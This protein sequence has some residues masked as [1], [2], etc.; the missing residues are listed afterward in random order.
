MDTESLRMKTA[1]HV[2]TDLALEANEMINEK[3]SKS[4]KI[5]AEL[6]EGMTVKSEEKQHLILTEIEIKSEEA[7]RAIEKKKG[8]YVTIEIKRP[9]LDTIEI[10]EAV[11]RTLSDELRKFINVLDKKIP[12]IMVIGLGNRHITADSLGPRV[13]DKIVVTRHVKNI[14]NIEIDKRLGSVCAISP[15]VMG[16]TGIETGE[17][18]KGLVECVKPDILF[19]VDALAARS[20]SRINATIQI[21]DTGIVPG[22]GVGNHRMELSKEK[23]GVPVIAIGVPTVVD[24]QT[25]IGDV[26]QQLNCEDCTINKKW[27]DMNESNVRE[28][29]SSI[30][31]MV[32]TPKNIDIAI[33][34][35]SDVVASGLNVATH[36]GF[37]IEEINEYLI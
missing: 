11:A 3:K 29:L 4:M 35:I 33:E 8:R 12:E 22:S 16:L 17:I 6:P 30:I 2:K 19:V 18:V 7:E 23:L 9:E 26:L 10:Q 24:A 20:M 15:G 36:Q 13:V 34:R 5:N 27:N 14:Q 1:H 31:N 25:L 32:V 21:S 28:K 37:E